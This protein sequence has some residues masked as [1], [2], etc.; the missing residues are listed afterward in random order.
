MVALFTTGCAAPKTPESFCK[1]YRSEKS[2][3]L[4]KYSEASKSLAD[5]DDSGAGALSALLMAGSALGDVVVMFDK[6]AKAAP[7][8]IEP[9]VSNIHDQMQKQL[10]GAGDNLS[11]PFSGLG[12]VLAAGFLTA[13]SWQRFDA[14]VR[15]HCDGG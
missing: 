13:G 11:N 2:A 9:D 1:V 5:A 8:D 6:L 15:E 3:Y 10:E 4:D 12:S 14:Y 7:E